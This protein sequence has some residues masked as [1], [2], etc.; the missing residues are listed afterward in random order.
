[1]DKNTF[2]KIVTVPTLFTKEL[3]QDILNEK[4]KHPYCAIL[5]FLDLLGDKACGNI[6]W[7]TAVAPTKMYLPGGFRIDRLL[8]EAKLQEAQPTTDILQEINAYQETSFKTAPKSVILSKFLENEVCEGL[9]TEAPATL[10]VEEIA[11]KS[12]TQDDSLN[13]ETLALIYEKQKKYDKAIA[14]YQKLISK[15]PEKSSIFAS[16]INEINNILETNKNI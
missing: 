4:L 12:I 16:R 14:I 9:N 15:N 7:E 11:K 6:G 5:Q 1:M 10:P 3:K 2:E 13:T 8:S